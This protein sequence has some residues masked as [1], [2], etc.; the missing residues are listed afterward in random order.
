M[1]SRFSH[2]LQSEADLVQQAPKEAS[3]HKMFVPLSQ[4]LGTD[5][6]AALLQ[7]S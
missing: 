1:W 7:H 3:G 5:Y 6:Y 2:I 4:V